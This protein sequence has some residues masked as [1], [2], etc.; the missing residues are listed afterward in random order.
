MK[1]AIV[2]SGGKQYIAREGE[3]IE[4]D[5]LPLEIGKPVS[6]DEVLLVADGKK[7]QVGGPLVKGASVKG[8]VLDQ[9]KSKKIIVFKYIPKERYRRKKGHR[10]HY[11][12]VRVDAIAVSGTKQ[13][14]AEAPAPKSTEA[15]KTKAKAPA[16]KSAAKKAASKTKAEVKPKAEAKPKTGA[17]PKVKVKPK[18]E[19]KP[20]AI[21]K[22]PAS[23][24]K[25]K[26]AAKSK[27]DAKSGGTKASAAKK[28]TSKKPSEKK[29]K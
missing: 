2:R 27:P 11:T 1:Y 4:V 6:F 29:D 22:K 21:S 15:E 19:E 26:S 12:R 8:E 28:T 13:V 17:K 9:V 14:A 16:A 24:A 23:S 25:P 20:K 10:Q 5:R 7:V 3:T 18:T